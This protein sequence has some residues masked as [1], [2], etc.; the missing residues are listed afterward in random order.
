MQCP[1]CRNELEFNEIQQSKID[2]AL[3]QLKEGQSLKIA[4]PH[5]KIAIMMETGGSVKPLA[6]GNTAQPKIVPPGPPD[7]SWLEIG[8]FEVNDIVEDVPQVMILVKDSSIQHQ[9]VESFSELGY[10]A[11]IMDSSQQAIERMRFESFNAIVY[12]TGFEGGNFQESPFHLHMR[13]MSM[14]KRR[15][16]YYVMVGPELHT[17]Y[18]LEALAYSANL[19]INDREMKQINILLRK[20][21][22]DYEE[23]F[24]LFLMAMQEYGKK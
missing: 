1:H 23:L 9:V 6:D 18:D 12:H 21:L 2:K 3:T 10:Q 14:S 4:C 24:G 13:A 8:E 15:Y 19:L 11:V 7:L 17:L 5:C 16:I 20:G 22:A